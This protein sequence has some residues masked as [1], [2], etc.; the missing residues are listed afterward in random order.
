MTQEESACL[1]DFFPRRRARNP[2]RNPWI[3]SN[4]VP[5]PSSYFESTLGVP[6]MAHP[7][8]EPAC[9]ATRKRRKRTQGKKTKKVQLGKI[10]PGG[11]F[12]TYV[13]LESSKDEHVM[14]K[15][16]RRKPNSHLRAHDRWHE[17][18]S[19]LRH[20]SSPNLASLQPNS[21]E[22]P[23]TPRCHRLECS[24]CLSFLSGTLPRSAM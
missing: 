11:F 14:K 8:C 5:L 7:H 19:H 15:K 22:S 23:P 4:V 21:F 13:I 20:M 1:R 3:R 16:T 10:Y 2:D 9:F 24:L 17:P 12:F 6:C 18:Y